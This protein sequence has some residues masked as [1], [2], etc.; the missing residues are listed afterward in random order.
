MDSAYIEIVCVQSSV[1]Y[2]EVEDAPGMRE[3][4]IWGAGAG[5]WYELRPAPSYEAVFDH[6]VASVTAQYLLE[7]IFEQ[8]QAKLTL[9]GIFEQVQ[10]PRRGSLR[11]GIY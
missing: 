2:Q 6:M 1:A 9:E 3:V 8:S 11:S 10:M 7:E 5:G 4:V